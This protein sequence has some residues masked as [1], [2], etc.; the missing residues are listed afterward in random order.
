M[1]NFIFCAMLQF[2]VEPRIF[3]EDTHI[4][5]FIDF[6]MLNLKWMLFFFKIVTSIL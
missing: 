2:I 3:C 1:E 5:V 6:D 4:H